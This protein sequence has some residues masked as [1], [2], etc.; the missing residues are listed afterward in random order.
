M[1]VSADSL[2]LL[3]HLADQRLQHVSQGDEALD[4]TALI[5]YQRYW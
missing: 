4:V 1:G 5:D 2:S 3:G